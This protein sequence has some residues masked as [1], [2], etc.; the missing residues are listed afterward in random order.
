M[1]VAVEE[2]KTMALFDNDQKAM[3]KRDYFELSDSLREKVMFV[4][5]VLANQKGEEDEELLDSAIWYFTQKKNHE[6]LNRLYREYK[7][8]GAVFAFAEEKKPTAADL[9][10]VKIVKK[11]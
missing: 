1:S 5:S 11:K 10:A 2:G 4:A 6:Q 7:N 3:I 9:R 8:D